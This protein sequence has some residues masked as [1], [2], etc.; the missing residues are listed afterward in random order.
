MPL[1]CFTNS[2]MAAHRLSFLLQ[3]LFGESLIVE[4]LSSYFNA[5]T[6]QQVLDKFSSGTVNGLVC[7]DALA[8]GIDIPNVE[9]VIS[10]E[11][12]MQI[13]TYIH[14]IGRT[15][16][17][18]RPGTAVTILTGDETNKFMSLVDTLCPNIQEIK[19]SEEYVER[20]SSEY[21]SAL[22]DMENA[23]KVRYFC[24]NYMG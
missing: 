16:R 12:A 2:K 10:Y 23:L 8:R 22:R 21:S 11:P 17:A 14:R 19:Y 15:A 18:G 6:R 20:I 13:P 7:S 4:E 1:S 3:R 24:F 9:V 5:K